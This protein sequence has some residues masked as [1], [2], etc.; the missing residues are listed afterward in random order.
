VKLPNFASR[1]IILS[2]NIQGMPEALLKI[3]MGVPDVFVKVLNFFVM[4]VIL[5]LVLQGMLE[6]L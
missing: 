4:V 3:L 2:L 6:A 5:S 1:V